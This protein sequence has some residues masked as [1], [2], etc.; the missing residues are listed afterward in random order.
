LNT[1]NTFSVRGTH[2]YMDAG[3]YP[4]VIVV[5]SP[6]GD[7]NVTSTT[8]RI[9]GE[10]LNFEAVD[11]AGIPTLPTGDIRVAQLLTSYQNLPSASDVTIDWG[12]GSTSPAVRIEGGLF[13][14]WWI[15]AN[16]TYAQ[17]GSYVMTVTVDD[18]GTDVSSSA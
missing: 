6:G 11:I 14:T 8:A 17:A 4:V 12:D 2:E 18:D 5:Q 15:I 3:N 13:N 1:D 10:P 7:L 16:H 9:W